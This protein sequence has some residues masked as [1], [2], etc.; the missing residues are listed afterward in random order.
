M[1]FK[2]NVSWNLTLGRKFSNILTDYIAI[3]LNALILIENFS[4]D[5]GILACD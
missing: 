1:Y 5:L 4:E 3:L 2:A